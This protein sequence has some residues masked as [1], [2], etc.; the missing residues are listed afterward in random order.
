M[1]HKKFLLLGLLILFVL[2]TGYSQQLDLNSK[3]E[4]DPKIKIG[5]LDN[6]LTYYIR[7]NHKPEK[8]V[9]LRLAIK[10]G[11]INETDL[12]QGLAHFVEHMAFNGSKN[13]KKNEL[14]DILEKMGIK[15]GAELNAYTSFNETVYMLTVPTDKPE[16]LEKSFL[17][18]EDWANNLSLEDKEIDK[19]RGVITEEWRLGL[20]ADDRM[21]KKYFPVLLKG[22]KYADRMPI[23]KI[24]VIKNFKYETLRSFYRDWYRPNLSAVIVVG[25]LE[26]TYAEE[27]IKKHFAGIK[28]PENQRPVETYIIPDNK[29]PLVAITT[30][31]EATESGLSIF[32]KHPKLA[33]NTI[34]DYRK[35][36]IL[37]NLF[38]DM[39]NKRL[40]EI[41]EKPECP[42][43][44]AYGSYGDFLA[45]DKDA[46]TLGVASK[47][48][49]ML[50]AFDVLLSENERVRRF[51]FTQTELERSKADLLS[52]FE[53]AAKEADKTE[54]SRFANEYIRH[55]L[56]NESIPGIENE[57]KYTK[58]L[59]PGINIEEI[60]KLASQLITDNNIGLAV[61][62]PEKKDIIIPTEKQILDIIQ[63]VKTKE[64]TAYIDNVSN[65]PLIKSKPAGSKV[66]SKKENKEF[67][68]TELT[69]A[70]GV[71]VILKSTDFK[72][73]EILFSGYSLGGTS[74]YPDKDLLSASFAAS[75][76]TDGGI[77]NFDKT[78]LD[79]KLAGKI[80]RINPYISDLREGF[81]GNASPKDFETLLQLTWLYFK[82]P[83]KDT[84]AYKAFI[85]KTKNQLKFIGS[86]PQM[87]FIDTIMKIIS[88]NSPRTITNLTLLKK[89]D[90]INLDV[91]YKIF[92]ERFAD[93]SDFNFFIVGNFKTDTLIPMLETYLGGLPSKK[94][95]ENWK[96]VEP[97]FPAG[98][99]ELTVYKGL[100]PQSM[101]AIAMKGKFEWSYKN[102]VVMNMLSSVLDIKLREKI[103][104]DKGGTYGLS[105]QFDTELYPEPSF[106]DFFFWGCSP[107]N[108]DKLSK[109]VFKEIKKIK[110]SGPEKVNVDKVKENL[111]RER[112]VNFKKNNFWLSRLENYYFMNIN[113]LSLEAYKDI[114]NSINADEIKKAAN[115][116]IPLDNLV[117]VVLK[118]EKKK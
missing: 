77:G 11:S 114:V 105:V 47:D 117:R 101:V 112:E 79:K 71:K 87:V 94:S 48:N 27:Q 73:D 43:I 46:Y 7:Q 39:L 116:Y 92:K 84:T 26:P 51:G 14:V 81:S 17:V 61:T 64:L 80:V 10:A 5:K 36:Y 113:L 6:G 12:Q 32:Y 4:I 89:M 111:C 106:T 65:E 33:E 60:N 63:K 57:L 85:S 53:R 29:E 107:K 98:K 50:E 28:N 49:Q 13:F 91:C 110:K 54:S 45:R 115:D 66:I 67:D 102:I 59:L 118:P 86:S 2:R 31:P 38:T 99:N 21:M 68:Y 82:E 75:I 58:S 44:Y 8:R 69:F 62:A 97:K 76:I 109:I 24:D 34:A 19:E 16:I 55:F 9:E 41:A 52:G 56:D 100:E 42:Y 103:R 23:G 83:R 40:Q 96:N 20:G 72:N 95:R 25:D 74:L 70:N 108:T 15:F 18:L 35:R 37:L 1:K 90:Q 3:V 22:S 93:G 88:S 30:D 104:E 78:Q